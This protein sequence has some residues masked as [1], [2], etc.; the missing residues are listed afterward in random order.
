MV[1]LFLF[2]HGRS[3]NHGVGVLHMWMYPHVSHLAAAFAFP[4]LSLPLRRFLSRT[5]GIVN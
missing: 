4:G 1:G 3:R 2:S 5:R